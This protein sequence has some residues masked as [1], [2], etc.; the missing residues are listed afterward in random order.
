MSRQ[1]KFQ[2][3]TFTTEVA[4]DPL[5]FAEIKASQ[6]WPD[7]S[8]ALETKYASLKKHKVFGEVCTELTKPPVGHKLIFSKKFDANG[9]LIMFKARLVAQRFSQRP[10]KDFDKTYAP[11]LD[12]IAFRYMLAFAVHFGLEIFMM[13]V[14]T[15]YMYGNLNMLLYI[16]PLLDFSP[17]LPTPSPGRFLGLR[18]CKALYGLKQADKMWYHLLRNFLISHGFLHDPTLPC[19]FILY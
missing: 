5:T 18:I 1:T 7:W 8:K 10:S 12:I 6:K 9:K 4:P 16:F 3:T 2:R 14:V 15:T 19:I 11:V 13:D 17:S